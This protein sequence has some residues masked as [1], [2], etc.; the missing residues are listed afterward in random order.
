MLDIYTLH[1]FV[2]EEGGYELCTR[3]RKWAKIA[4]RMNY[5]SIYILDYFPMH[6]SYYLF[7]YR[8]HGISFEDLL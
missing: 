1:L 2:K 5:T 6:A 7:I 4:V 8:K 3:D